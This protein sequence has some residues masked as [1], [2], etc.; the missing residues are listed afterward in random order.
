[1]E[2][3]PVKSV[4]PRDYETLPALDEPAGYIC[5]VRDIDRDRYRIEATHLPKAFINR[6]VAERQRSF[7]IELV[8]I[9]Q[10]DRSARQRSQSI[11]APPRAARQRVAGA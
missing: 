7:G 5:V 4:A 8:S 2:S 3:D 6:L 10:T 1:M 11:R 9:V